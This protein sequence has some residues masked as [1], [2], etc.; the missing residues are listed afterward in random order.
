[1]LKGLRFQLAL[2]CSTI[3]GLILFIICLISLQIS[4]SQ[5]NSRNQI[6]FENQLQTISY[7]LQTQRNI[8]SSW[9]AQLEAD[10]KL[11]IS[12]EDNGHPF[13]SKVPGLPLHLAMTFF[14]KLIKMR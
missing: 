10:N 11:I 7:Q 6:A 5:L 13:S 1:M 4:E 12:I 2:I 8:K 9:L 3:T 14:N